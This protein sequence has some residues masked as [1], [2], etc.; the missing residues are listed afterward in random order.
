MEKCLDLLVVG[1]VAFDS[2]KTPFAERPRIL[3]GSASY[4]SLAASCFTSVKIVSVVGDDFLQEHRDVFKDRPIDLRGLEVRKGK[5]FH[6]AGEYHYDF[7]ERTTLATELNVFADFQPNIPDDYCDAPVVFLANIDPELQLEVLEKVRNPRLVGCDTMNFWIE[8]KPDALAKLLPKLDILV[9]N[10]EEARQLA[11]EA[12]TLRAGMKIVGMG[13][14]RVVIK[15]GEYGVISMTK[16]SFFA[17][18]AYPIQDVEDPTGAGDSFGGGMFGYLAEK[19]IFDEVH[20][21]RSL[22]VGSA[23]ASFCVER[24]GVEGLLQCDTHSIA[25]R[26]RIFKKHTAFEDYL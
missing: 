14:D 22:V 21:R 8:S 24:F 3:G 25:E 11:S 19:G 26:Y 5:T 9:I 20:L 18:T 17:T 7:N 1:S 23:V 12:N 15:R 2:I 6:W 16:D 4:F 10:E 13:P